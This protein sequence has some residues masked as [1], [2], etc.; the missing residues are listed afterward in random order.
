MDGKNGKNV[1]LVVEVFSLK[2]VVAEVL[3]SSYLSD[4]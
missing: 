4:K 3:R 1:Y 2:N